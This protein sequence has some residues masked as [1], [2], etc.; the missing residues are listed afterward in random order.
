M[1]SSR[2]RISCEV[3]NYLH[4]NS[5]Y[6]VNLKTFGGDEPLDLDLNELPVQFHE[7]DSH[8]DINDKMSQPSDIIWDAGGF[9]FKLIGGGRPSLYIRLLLGR[10]A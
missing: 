2:K 10:E 7:S 9:R 4:A 1:E 6:R 3:I 5:T 8:D